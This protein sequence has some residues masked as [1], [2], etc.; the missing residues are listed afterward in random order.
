MSDLERSY[1]ITLQHLGDTLSLKDAETGGHSKRTTAFT[2][3]IGRAMGISREQIAVIARAAFL[4]DIGKMAIPDRTCSNR[5]SLT[6]TSGRSCANIAIMATR[7]LRK[8]HFSPKLARLFTRPTNTMTAP[9]TLGACEAR[10]YRW[11]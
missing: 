11:V 4:H 3:V 5:E 2:I 6:M 10:R 7:C 9:N 1:D 8:S